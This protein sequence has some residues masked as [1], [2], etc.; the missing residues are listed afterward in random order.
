MS[1]GPSGCGVA[2]TSGCDAALV[3]GAVASAP[4]RADRDVQLGLRDIDPDEHRRVMA[5]LRP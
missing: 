1:V 2:S 5:S 3:V 4:P